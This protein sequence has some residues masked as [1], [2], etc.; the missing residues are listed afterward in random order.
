MESREPLGLLVDLVRATRGRAD[1]TAPSAPRRRRSARCRRPTPSTRNVPTDCGIFVE[2]IRGRYSS[3]STPGPPRV[4][5]QDCVPG[6][7]EA[8]RRRRLRV[9]QRCAR[10]IEQLAA[11]LVA[12]ASQRHPLE[13]RRDVAGL[14]PAHCAM[15]PR[16]GRAER[17]EVAA[18]EQLERVR[19]RSTSSGPIQRLG[20]LED[21]RAPR[22]H[23]PGGRH[24]DELEPRPDHPQPRPA[25][26]TSSS[27]RRGPTAAAPQLVGLALEVA[28]ARLRPASR[29]ATTRA[30]PVGSRRRG[31]RSRA[32]RRRGS[33]RA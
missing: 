23:V 12:E 16:R 21:V 24:A 8:H 18:H 2:K 6:R 5:E 17:A 9:G 11:R 27:C 30:A 1:R 7:Q 31:A 3:G 32:A 14:H 15:S 19:P 10:E 20:R 26:S 13:R 25:T 28:L 22:S 33:W 4:H 29:A